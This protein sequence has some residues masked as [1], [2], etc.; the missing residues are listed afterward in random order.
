VRA[1]REVRAKRKETCLRA[2]LFS[3]ASKSHKYKEQGRNEK[4]G[5]MV[6]RLGV[7]NDPRTNAITNLFP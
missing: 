1:D 2:D 4:V 6:G 3:E 7:F 5:S